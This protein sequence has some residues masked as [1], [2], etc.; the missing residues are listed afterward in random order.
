MPA[1][2][3]IDPDAVEYLARLARRIAD[4]LARLPAGD[5]AIRHAADELLAFAD[6]SELAA[7]RVRETDVAAADGFRQAQR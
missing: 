1:D 7:R 2:L 3:Q 5:P 4:D 6:A